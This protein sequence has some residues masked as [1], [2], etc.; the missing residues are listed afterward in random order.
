MQLTPSGFLETEKQGGQG[1][2][3]NILPYRKLALMRLIKNYVVMYFK[4]IMR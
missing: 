1:E 3:D 2:D 4:S